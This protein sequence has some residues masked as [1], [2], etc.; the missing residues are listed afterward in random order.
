MYKVEISS[1]R[2]THKLT[3]ILLTPDPGTDP[4][5]PAC[6]LDSERPALLLELEREAGVP[7]SKRQHRTSRRAR[8]VGAALTRREARGD[9][10]AV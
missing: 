2:Y 7:C 8:R 6:P 9:G 4:R 10:A 1:Y 3:S 5:R